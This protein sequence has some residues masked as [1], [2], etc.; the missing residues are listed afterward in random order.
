MHPVTVRRILS[1]GR[2]HSTT[3]TRIRTAMERLGMAHLMPES[4][5]SQTTPANAPMPE[6]VPA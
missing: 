5:R 1:G 3:F 6:K 2:G 4:V